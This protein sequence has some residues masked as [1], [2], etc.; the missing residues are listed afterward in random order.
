MRKR[1][2]ALLLA[3]VLTFSQSG[4]IVLASTADSG[5]EQQI[6]TQADDVT[7]TVN[8][9]V[10]SAEGDAS[11][12]FTI[13]SGSFPTDYSFQDVEGNELEEGVDYIENRAS[14]ANIFIGFPE[15]E[16]T[17]E[18]VFNLVIDGKVMATV[19]QE[20]KADE[21]TKA[22]IK[23]VTKESQSKLADGR[24]QVVFN[25]TGTNLKEV[26]VKVKEGFS[27][28][29]TSK[30][31]VKRD[32]E[33]TEQ[34]ITITLP[35]NTD[36]F[37]V[38]Y[39]IEFYN[40]TTDTTVAVTHKVTIEP[41][42]TETAEPAITGVTVD[43]SETEWNEGTVNVTVKGTDLTSDLDVAVLG[44]NGLAVSTAKVG[45]INGTA[46]EQTFSVELPDNIATAD[47]A[48]TISVNVKGQTDKKTAAV[49]VKGKDWQIDQTITKI[50]ASQTEISNDDRTVEFTLEGENLC[51]ITGIKVLK[52]AISQDLSSYNVKIE[53]KGTTQKIT[54]T[55][56][57]NTGSADEEYKVNFYPDGSL[58]S[59]FKSCTVKVLAEETEP[60]IIN[61][62]TVDKANFDSEGGQAEFAVEGENINNL[63]N[64]KPAVKVFKNGVEDTTITPEFP[65]GMTTV[66]KQGFFITFP[67]NTTTKDV[68]YT[69]K[70]AT[71]EDALE[72]EWKET[73]VTVAGKEE[74]KEGT[75]TGITVNPTE[76]DKD[77]G[78]VQLKVE[79]TDLTAKN[80]GVEVKTVI[81]ET[82]MDRTQ[83][84]PATV[85]DITADGATITIPENGMVNNLEYRITAGALK[86]GTVQ[87]QAT[88]KVVQ[89]GGDKRETLTVSGAYLTDDN[90]VVVDFA[91]NVAVAKSAEDLKS[92]ISLTGYEA[93]DA[94]EP[95]AL[96]TSDT[97]EVNGKT[98][99]IT[100]NTEYKAKAGSQVSIGAGAL[101]LVDRDVTTL[102][103][104]VA[105]SLT[106][107]ATVKQI[108]FEKDVFDYKG[109]TVVAKLSGVRLEELE[110]GSIE[111]TITNPGTLKTA[112]IPV[113]VSYGAEP[114][115]EFTVPENTTDATQSY[116]LS[117]KVNGE[118]VYEVDG[119]NLARRAIVSVLPKVAKESDQ[120]LGSMTITGN[121]K[122]DVGDPTKITVTVEKQVGSLKTVLRL[123][124]TNLDSTKTE[125]RAIDEN[126]IIW[127]VYHIPECDGSWRF[128]AIDGIN[129]NGVIGDGN[130]QFVE[131]LPPRYAGTNKTYK[132][133][134]ALDGVHFLDAP[135]VELTVDNSAV[136]GQEDE[137]VDCGKEDI[138]NIKAKYI[139]QKTGKEIAEADNYEG[140]PISMYRQFDIGAKE[141]PG[142][143][144]VKGPNMDEYKDLFYR[145][146][147]VSEFVFE[148]VS[149]KEV[150]TGW[151]QI[152]GKWYYMDENGE[153][154]TDWQKV[155][156]KWYYMDKNGVMQTGWQK[157]DGKW[158]YMNGSG[159]ML[160]GWQKIGGKWYY[161]NTSGAM[162]TGWQK[163]GGKWYYMNGSGAMLTGWQKIGGKW[164]YM[165]GSGAMLTGWQKIGGK[166]YYMNTSGAMQ[167]GWLKLGNQW[168]YLNASGAMV[169]GSQKIGGKWYR[170]NAS[171]VWIK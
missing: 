126:G 56:P 50:T 1:L 122:L 79:G 139:D 34:K 112:D 46:T 142:Y 127:P 41:A 84:Y 107:K 52:S 43:N 42:D 113:K 94:A 170:F 3:G 63:P 21:S 155:D 24:T 147:P 72:A 18:K 71:S 2:Y 68:V 120:T 76:I 168:Y 14:G 44:S 131:I 53:G 150:K 117:L 27:A 171:G 138:V 104:D 128:V 16:E 136:K 111:A 87:S 115:V 121:N 81:E 91:E 8:K 160:T 39:T 145:D 101:K 5:S 85:S 25:A 9:S 108:N 74:A 40:T 114:T 6:A 12:K 29:N 77:G 13:S 90:K 36:E 61:G 26:G 125:V 95:G 65:N 110:E 102:N 143:K 167:T 51:N 166:W 80:W 20:G 31:T 33:G 23:K 97:V 103:R 106:H 62:L 157:V 69:V 78:K 98:L 67:E 162:L 82:E 130:S 89:E 118:N 158:Y 37:A 15:N 73:T 132:I 156:G 148:Y 19:T 93:K 35:A 86:D 28:V 10:I 161:M 54:M 75:V 152:D 22:V 144:L 134:V 119:S 4:M 124:G 153:A 129:K 66:F 165:N 64:G 99:T 141:I 123:S 57:E 149:E 100:L 151:Q 70:A 109:G 146:K 83:Q 49:T 58:Y 140:Y 116:L 17:T 59:I 105:H 38:N 45:K 11:V 159:A 47:K 60:A 7:V 48:Y 137:W 164:Y 169:T 96:G 135:T 32:G 154:K 92:K 55:F 163:I 133:Q 30:Y 88:A